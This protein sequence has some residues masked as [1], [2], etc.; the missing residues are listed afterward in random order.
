MRELCPVV[1]QF[2]HRLCFG[3]GTLDSASSIPISGRTSTLR[4]FWAFKPYPSATVKVP[5]CWIRFFFRCFR[6]VASLFTFSSLL[7]WKYKSMAVYI[8]IYTSFKSWPIAALIKVREEFWCLANRS[9]RN[10]VWEVNSASVFGIFDSHGV[11]SGGE[12][13]GVRNL[14]SSFE[15]TASGLNGTSPAPWKLAWILL[16]VN[17]A[18]KALL[19]AG[20][21]S[22]LV[23]WL[24]WLRIKFSI[25]RPYAT[26]SGAKQPTSS[27]WRR[28]DKCEGMQS[29]MMFFFLQKS[30]NSIELWLSWPSIIRSRKAPV[31]RCA[32]CF[33][34][35]L[36][37]SK[38]SSFVVQPLSLKEIAQSRGVSLL[39]HAERWCLPAKMINGGIAQPCALIPWIAVTH[40]RFPG[41]TALGRDRLSE[42]VITVPVEITPI[43]NPVSS[44]L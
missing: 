42:A 26:F 4:P 41:C 37:H 14:I 31:L 21:N 16:F 44:K 20:R 12:G 11:V 33:S 10:F 24:M 32:V 6:C 30:W 28:W 1:P 3:T 2:L 17:V 22:S 39:Y 8:I 29:V 38:P 13:D 15:M 27:G 7:T 5:R 23:M 35:C 9:S 36:I 34:K 25:C 18:S 40:S 19:K 43:W